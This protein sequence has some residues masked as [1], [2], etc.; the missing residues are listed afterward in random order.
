MTITDYKLIQADGNRELAKEVKRFIDMGEGWEPFEGPA[1][2]VEDKDVCGNDYIYCQA[3]VKR[4]PESEELRQLRWLYAEAME[5]VTAVE[6]GQVAEESA[7]AHIA[8]T[9][10]G[11]KG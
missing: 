10:K 9:L 6:M 3:I 4:E 8:A 2:L 1:L 7:L 11:M 5:A